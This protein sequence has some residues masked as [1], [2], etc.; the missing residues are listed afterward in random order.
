MT[1][2]D[3]YF[4]IST[5]TMIVI[6]Y[7]SLKAA[8][9]FYGIYWLLRAQLWKNYFTNMQKWETLEGDVLKTDVIE[10][11]SISMQ[12]SSKA[13]HVYLPYIKYK[14][15]QNGK[16]IV[17]DTF[18]FFLYGFRELDKKNVQKLLRKYIHDG[19]VTV[20]MNPK[21]QFSLL[22][23]DKGIWF[24]EFIRMHYIAGLPFILIGIMI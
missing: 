24:N 7:F 1:L 21:K 19:K 12:V 10:A 4:W 17:S 9:V 5:L 6:A 3:R 14:Y 16:E 2:F 15:I 23:I 22:D 20:Y 8:F 11:S 18:S 13:S